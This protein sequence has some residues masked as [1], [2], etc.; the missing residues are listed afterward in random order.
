MHSDQKQVLLDTPPPFLNA[1]TVE[2][3][4]LILCKQTMIQIRLT[5]I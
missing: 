2:T 3:E 5:E 4:N 1:Y